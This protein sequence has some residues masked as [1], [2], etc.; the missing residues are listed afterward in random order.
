MPEEINKDTI[1]AIK[2]EHPGHKLRQL[3]A[4]GVTVI[5]RSPTEPEWERF[6]RDSLE[7]ARR[8][9]A[10]ERLVR[11]CCV[12]PEKKSVDE[13]LARLPGLSITFGDQIAELGGITRDVE[14]KD[15]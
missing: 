6:Q 10:M 1:A 12:F 14:K 4:C 2:A 5:I 13:F 9:K 8:S 15:L 11:D 3:S 7:P